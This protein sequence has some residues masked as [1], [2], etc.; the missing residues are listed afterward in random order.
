M[1]TSTFHNYVATFHVPRDKRPGSEFEIMENL[2]QAA[3]DLEM[4]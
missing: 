4:A 3:G 2:G 1:A